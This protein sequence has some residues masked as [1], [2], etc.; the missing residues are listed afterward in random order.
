LAKAGWQR[1][2]GKRRLAYNRLAKANADSVNTG[3]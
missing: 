1:P 3:A 2:V